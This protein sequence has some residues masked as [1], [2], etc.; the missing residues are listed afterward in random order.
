[1]REEASLA[2]ADS[3]A[4]VREDQVAD[5]V[6]AAREV[7]AMAA[8][9]TEAADSAAA[10]RGEAVREEASSF[11]KPS[12]SRRSQQRRRPGCPSMYNG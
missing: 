3:A 2:A 5:S 1:M 6:A 12:L 11:P 9:P 8:E 4:A 10:A 7:A